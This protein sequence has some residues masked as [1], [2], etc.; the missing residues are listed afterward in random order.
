M[1]IKNSYDSRDDALISERLS[2]SLDKLF[3]WT[4]SWQLK[5]AV[6]KCAVLHVGSKNPRSMYFLGGS[7]L[8]TCS[9]YKDLGLIIDEKLSFKAQYNA[10]ITKAYQRANINW[11]LKRY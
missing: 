2:L 1:S 11:I 9:N 5:L 4:K 10:V 8:R 3:A 6:D 7:V